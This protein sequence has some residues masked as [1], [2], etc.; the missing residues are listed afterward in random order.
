MLSTLPLNYIPYPPTPRLLVNDFHQLQ[1]I[2]FFHLWNWRGSNKWSCLILVVTAYSEYPWLLFLK[3]RLENGDSWLFTVNK[4]FKTHLKKHEPRLSKTHCTGKRKKVTKSEPAGRVSAA[5]I[6]M[7]DNSLHHHRPGRHGK[8]DGVIAHEYWWT[9]LKSDSEGSDA[10]VT[11]RN[12][13]IYCA[14][15]PF[16][17][18]TK[19]M[20]RKITTST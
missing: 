13:S 1:D 16:N 11:F 7:P 10:E 14:Y 17:A 19:V 18:C 3:A 12:T 4:P 2:D 9:E 20:H 5:Q 8:G 6:K 15:V